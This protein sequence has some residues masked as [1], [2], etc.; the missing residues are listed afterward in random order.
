[1]NFCDSV[2][3][4]TNKARILDTI[5]FQ[6]PDY[7]SHFVDFTSQ[8]YEKMVRPTGNPDYRQTVNNHI[9]I[10]VLNPPQQEIRPGFFRDEFGVIWNKAGV[11]KDIG[12]IDNIQSE[13]PEDIGEIPKDMRPLSRRADSSRPHL[14]GTG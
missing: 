4:V 5:H 3:S 8:M 7:I 11:D 14:L 12:V 1:M 2:D 6:E 10:L 9:T 13:D